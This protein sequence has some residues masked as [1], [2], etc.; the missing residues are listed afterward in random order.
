MLSIIYPVYDSGQK[1][2][3]P[4]KEVIQAHIGNWGSYPIEL[5]KQIKIIIVDDGSKNPIDISI[6]FP[7]NL[8]L[9]RINKDIYWNI[10]GALNLGHKLADNDWSFHSDI[11]HILKPSECKK[12]LN[13]DK[14]RSTVYSITRNCEY[15]RIA[16][17]SF[18]IHNEDYWKTGGYD[19]DFAGNSGWNDE[20]F[21]YLI[22]YAGF[23][24]VESTIDLNYYPHFA[25]TFEKKGRSN[26][27]NKLMMKI[28]QMRSG[29]YKNG[30]SI[31]FDWKIVKEYKIH[32]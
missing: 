24:I 7:I 23:H 32:D 5:R 14:K 28:N 8:I 4:L 19:E 17:N 15:K 21:K 3:T 12:M 20:M 27:G 30:K 1:N 16:P 31:R 29:N 26:N 2:I 11:D 6:S 25:S 18:L 13:W 9:A 10:C 22:S